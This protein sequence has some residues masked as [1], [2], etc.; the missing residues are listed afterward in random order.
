MNLIRDDGAG[1]TTVS[2]ETEPLYDYLDTL[3]APITT[4]DTAVSSFTFS[5]GTLAMTVSNGDAYSFDLDARYVTQDTFVSGSTFDVTNGVLTI[6]QGMNS[7][8]G[9][10]NPPSAVTVDLDGRYKLDT[11]LDV[12]ISTLNFNPANGQLYAARNDGTNTVTES[13]DG[14][15]FDDVSLSGT[16]FTFNRTNGNNK[17]INL[18]PQR[19]DV[20]NGAK[21][22]FYNASAPCGYVKVTTSVLNN[23]ALR[24]VT[25]T[26][27]GGDTTGTS[28]TNTFSS[29]RSDNASVN[30]G[31][32]DVG[33]GVDVV[34]GSGFAVNRGNL[35]LTGNPTAVLGSGFSINITGNPSPGNL[36]AA[37]HA[38]SQNQMPSHTHSY[39]R[40]TFNGRADWDD[41][42]C[43]RGHQTVNTGGRGGGQGHQHNMN[44]NPGRGNL[45]TSISGNL[46]SGR[47]NLAINGNPSVSGDISSS[48]SS[49][50]NITGQP[51]FSAGSINLKVKYVDVII[52]ERTTSAVSYTHLTLP[53]KRI[54]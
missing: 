13:L 14:R 3:Y 39:Q 2:I 41:G 23:S 18:N 33:G 9:N 44:G 48:G 54:V 31:N 5:S 42:S 53:T 16:T 24:V 21:M 1:D 34:F 32:L 11:A 43:S 26:G 22:L 10:P 25:G 17:V 47:G 6:T 28:F 27:G 46:T 8:F 50:L 35:G 20:P 4:V 29:S 51:T 49:Q 37:N 19:I 52:A 45:G 40:A 30:R 38:V 7:P 12:A 15:Y 36:K